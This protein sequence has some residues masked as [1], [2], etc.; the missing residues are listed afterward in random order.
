M[1][2]SWE[3]GVGEWAAGLGEAVLRKTMWLEALESQEEGRP[4]PPWNL[5]AECSQET[6]RLQLRP[7]S[8]RL[9]GRAEIR[10]WE[11]RS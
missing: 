1:G 11:E 4:G 6:L 8:H 10:A 9:P 5:R 3:T 2:E 7:R